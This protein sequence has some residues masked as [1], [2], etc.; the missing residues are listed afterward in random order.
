[1]SSGSR[2]A[3]DNPILTSPFR[4][5]TQHWDFSGAVA[6][7]I[8]GRRPAQHHGIARTEQLGSGAVAQQET[9]RLT[10][11][12]EIRQ[13]VKE[14]RQA[15]YPNVTPTTRDL[16]EH[17]NRQDRERPLF[18]C[19][20]EAVET[21]IW[22][23]EAIPADRQGVEIPEDVPADEE[24]LAKEYLPL[25]RYCTKIAT[26]GG[27]TLVMAMLAAWTILNRIAARGDGRFSKAVLV[28]APNLTVKERLQVLKPHVPGNY[29]EQFDLV[30]SQYLD[31]VRRGR[32]GI[33]NWHVFNVRDDTSRRGV[34]K[35]GRE[36]DS[37]IVRRALKA[38]GLTRAH[39][40]LVLNDEAHHAWRP[41]AP[42]GSDQLELDFQGLSREEKAEAMEHGEEATVWVGG[43]DR[44][45]KVLGKGS[46][47]GIKLVVD[48]S[49][50]P[51]ALKGSGRPEGEPFPWIV[52]DF[53]LVDAIESGITKVPRIPIRDD[54]G[55]PDPDYFHLWSTIKGRL[56]TS[57]RGTKRRPPKPEAVWR[58]A[59]GALSTLAAK[60]AATKDHFELCGYTVPPAMVVV[61]PNTDIAKVFADGIRRGDV[62]DALKDENTFQIDTKVLKEAEADDGGKKKD[63]EVLL[64]LKTATVGKAE[65]EGGAPPPSIQNLPEDVRATLDVPPGKDVRCV[66]SVGMLTEG[67]DAR[68][69][70]QILG[71]RAFTSQLLCEQVV[72]RALRRMSYDFDEEGM[73]TPEYA[74][75]F[76]VPFEVIPVQGTAS[77]VPPPS[78]VSALV[79]AVPERKH[80]A[81][82]FPRVEG[83]VV[84]VRERIRCDVDAIPLVRIDA[85]FEPTQVVTTA[86]APVHRGNALGGAVGGA[87]TLTRERFHKEHRLQRTAFEMSRDVVA[88]LAQGRTPEGQDLDFKPAPETARL[89]FPQVL[90]YV[91]EFLA[92]RIATVGEARREEIA[93][94]KYRERAV[95]RILEAIEPDREAGETPLLPRIA[96][97]HPV[98][99]T[100]DVQFRTLKPTIPTH[101]SHI[102]HVVSD[103][104]WEGQATHYLE[105]DKLEGVVVAYAKNDRLGFTIPYE[106]SGEQKNY[107]PDFVVRVLLDDQTELNLV[108]E[109]KGY[110]SEDA[111][112]KESAAQRWVRAVNHHGGFGRWAYHVVTEPHKIPELLLGIARPRI[113]EKEPAPAETLEPDDLYSILTGEPKAPPVVAPTREAWLDWVSAAR[114][115]NYL[116]RDPL[117][118]W[119]SLHGEAQ[120][121]VRDDRMDGY[122]TQT[123]FAPFIMTKGRDFKEAVVGHV[124]TLTGVVRI[125]ERPEDTRDPAKAQATLQAMKEGVPVLH[126]GVL[127]D[128]ETRTYGSP[129]LLVRSDVLLDLFPDAYEYELARQEFHAQDPW[130][131]PAPL[132]GDHPWHYRVV[133]VKFT[134][135]K[136]LKS[137]ELGN[138]GSA[139]AYKGQVFLYNRA[140]GRLQGFQPASSFLLGRSWSQTGSR[141][142][143]CMERL[144]VVPQGTMLSKTHALA[145]EVENAVKWVR[146]VRTEGATWSVLPEPSV[147]EL[148][149]NMKFTSD[150]PWHA[151]K[152]Q[153]ATELR[154]LTLLWNVGVDKREKA[155]E[156][157]I[158]RWDD[159]NL[160]PEKAGVRG[161][162]TAPTLAALLDINTN[163][164]GPSVRPAKITKAG[165]EWCEPTPLEFFVDFETV[166]D[167]DDHL[168][169]IPDK[170]GQ[171][172]IF[173]IGCGHVV[174]GEWVFRCFT[175]SSLTESAE[176]QIIEDWLVHMT[177]VQEQLGVSGEPRVFHWSPAEVSTLESA[178][179]SAKKRHRGERSEQWAVPDWFD[180]LN[181]VVKAEPVVIRGAMG[182]GLKAIAKAL[183]AQ[184]KIQTLWG[185]GPTDG[186]GA[187]VGAWRAWKV[188]REKGIPL[189]EVPLMHEIQEYNEVDCKVMQEVIAFLRATYAPDDHLTELLELVMAEEGEYP[190]SPARIAA[191]LSRLAL[192]APQNDST[193]E[194][195]VSA[196][197]RWA[198]SQAKGDLHLLWTA[199]ESLRGDPAKDPRLAVATAAAL[200]PRA[201]A[202]DGP[203]AALRHL[204]GRVEVVVGRDRLVESLRSQCAE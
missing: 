110:V 23:T 19:Q 154:D 66:V 167:L 199:S 16:L 58:E 98:G 91:R 151:A 3:V 117:L 89:L 170:D 122:D 148:R 113:F 119:L 71:L 185:D 85:A 45:N 141:G 90:R 48:L 69:V 140:L 2:N 120:G 44:V 136:L 34:V 198:A 13:R 103:S 109:T 28:V 150:A 191:S 77:K 29:Y 12:N 175:T 46:Q 163:S 8:E 200:V 135:L 195:V 115:R 161:Q 106:V 188:A 67:W 159:P 184:G 53:S 139:P 131:L 87:E 174:Q 7:T 201:I 152:R 100:E 187:M 204:A 56:S 127:H 70:T 81:L 10:R 24:S 26:G 178:Y 61:A 40:L 145:E 9:L 64:R 25:T 49:A 33:V 96:R 41:A 138:S 108:L 169:D 111:K 164:D 62:L 172:L 147:P 86:G 52:S 181:R 74:D 116:L 171:P 132:L 6:T 50:T 94:P 104:T 36:T 123:D 143:N 15:N 32:V 194:D 82:Q 88:A 158:T 22:L 93:L 1:M 193:V 134:S 157:G 166:S 118:D 189:D 203:S 121:F 126:Q 202:K 99:S 35:K 165:L 5:P 51:F 79:Q 105:S 37:A 95:V 20:R 11:V 4:E 149:P 160:T 80:L 84:D 196:L 55:R 47:R 57:E 173:M 124:Q 182:F 156:E 83:Y 186:L 17:W 162:K 177:E 63:R 92:K 30:P 112:T 190:V 54:S 180:F 153:V 27:K 168:R 68:N 125:A 97:F 107:I 18:F 101:R 78:K 39:Q 76:G 114:I 133:D 129:D 65:W 72:G 60:W 137:G 183:H 130:T 42:I 146:R 38:A 75:I 176:A 155:A 73:L 31:L 197:E 144:A 14:W 192:A 21:V 142:F 43:L 128:A 179:N 59:S 102:S